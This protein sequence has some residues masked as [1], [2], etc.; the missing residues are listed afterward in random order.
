MLKKILDRV[1]DEWT[2]GTENAIK[3]FIQIP[4][5]SV[6][7]DKD[8]EKNRQLFK[9]VEQ[10]K[11][12]VESQGINGL[13]TRIIKDE[14]FTPCLLVEIEASETHEKQPTV[15][16]YGHLDKQPENHGWDE[17]KGPWS[18]VV[19]DGK[20]YGRGAA[21]DGYSFFCSLT[22]VKTLQTL[23][24]PHPRCV[25]LFE[26][27]EES[28]SVHYEEYL[29][30]GSESLK[31]VGLVVALDSS[32]GDYERLWVTKSLRGMI[33]GAI[34]VEVL[35]EGVHSGE[36]SGI[37][38]ESFMIVRS[39]LDRVEDSSTGEIKGN[40]FHQK[41]TKDIKKQ[42]A[43]IATVLGDNLWQQYPWVGETKPLKKTAEA[44]VLNRNWEPALTITGMDGMPSVE[45]GGNVLRPYTRVKIGMRLPP[46]VDAKKASEAFGKIVT[47]NPPFSSKVEYQPV[48]ASNGWVAEKPVAWLEKAFSKASMKYWGND[49]CYLGMGASIPLLNVF[50][51]LWPQS[52]FLVAGVL[53]PKSN[54]HGPN[55]F[56][57]I[58]YA[59][60]LT[61][62]V[63]YVIAKMGEKAK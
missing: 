3:E 19:Q 46:A 44:C 40:V 1:C 56:L 11:A 43:K 4:A 31:N 42:C 58:E 47:E 35:S 49:F 53:G 21:D 6:D 55:E 33:G 41:I 26:T 8:W 12:W 28:S 25:G 14:G 15:F 9:A 60:R 5:L 52:Q 37:V 51:K 23:G 62:T 16:L 17:D 50:S 57:H 63:A 13:S 45:N 54:A 20:L 48:V 61:A 27:C 2:L 10:A 32:C 29:E 38:P 36:A 7:F 24:I 22:A 39:L 59:Q 34:N 18:P 30:E